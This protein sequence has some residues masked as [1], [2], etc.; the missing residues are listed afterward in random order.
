MK[1]FSREREYFFQIISIA[2]EFRILAIATLTINMN[3]QQA[4]E[5][6]G[7]GVRS[8]ERYMGQN[9]KVAASLALALKEGAHI[10]TRAIALV[11][12]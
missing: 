5:F 9:P 1:V 11:D 7:I 12:L 10:L 8:L 2:N 6:L 3:K 4:A